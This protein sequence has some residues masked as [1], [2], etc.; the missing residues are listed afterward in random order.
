VDDWEMLDDIAQSRQLV[1]YS[2]TESMDENSQS[3]NATDWANPSQSA[4]LI[5]WFRC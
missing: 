2:T 3:S 5:I 1:I 4:Y